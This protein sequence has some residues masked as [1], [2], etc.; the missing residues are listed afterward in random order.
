[1]K[2]APNSNGKFLKRDVSA[3][4]ATL[5]DAT[6]VLHAVHVLHVLATPVLVTRYCELSC[7]DT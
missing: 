7:R 5:P 3:E 1:M 6:P 4:N 2:A